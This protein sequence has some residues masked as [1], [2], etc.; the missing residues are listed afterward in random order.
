MVIS[1]SVNLEVLDLPASEVDGADVPDWTADPTEVSST[2][3]SSIWATLEPDCP[4]PQF[5]ETPSSTSSTSQP[6]KARIDRMVDDISSPK[7]PA[8]FGTAKLSQPV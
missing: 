6:T 2:W 1:S 8:R 3:E 5:A 7:R 4:E